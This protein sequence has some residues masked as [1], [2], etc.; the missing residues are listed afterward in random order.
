MLLLVAVLGGGAGAIAV[1]VAGAGAGA[2]AGAVAAAVA[3]VAAA[4]VAVVVVVVAVV[5]V[6]VVVLLFFTTTDYRQQSTVQIKYNVTMAITCAPYPAPSLTQT[7]IIYTYK[8]R[9]IYASGIPKGSGKRD[10]SAT[11]RQ[12]RRFECRS[13]GSTLDVVLDW[14]PT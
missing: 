13:G 12:R 3:F 6:V 4:V 1:A 5:A 2:G 10:G 7:G 8:H 11:G 9:C 14:D